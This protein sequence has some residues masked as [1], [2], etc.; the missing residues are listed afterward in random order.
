[1]I[2]DIAPGAPS[3]EGYLFPDT[4]QFSRMMTMREMAAAMVC[5]FMAV[6]HQIGLAQPPATPAGSSADA[7]PGAGH[8]CVNTRLTMAEP[9]GLLVTASTRD[10]PAL[11]RTVI[12]AIRVEK[13]T[14]AAEERPLVASVYYNRL[15]K[16][17]ALN[18]D[19][20]VIM[21]NCSPEPTP[22][23]CTTPTCSFHPPTTP[24]NTPAFRPDQ[25]LT[26][27][28]ARSRR[29]CTP[30][31]PTT[32]I[33][34]PTPPGTIALRTR[35]KSTIRM[36]PPIVGPCWVT[37]SFRTAATFHP[38]LQNQDRCHS[39]YRFGSLFDGQVCLPQQ[40]V[41]FGRM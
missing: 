1:M 19:P 2:S 25:S 4:C 35:W 11:Q 40:T 10:L 39:V 22:E 32:I 23:P 14:S 28:G 27:A 41:C 26:Q 31:N 33:L 16:N 9:N 30:P 7:Y 12:M 6:A 34:C 8:N 20:S 3:L 24:T 21:R 13:E 5:Q 38:P 37:S 17:I 29:R 36:Q 18:A 15:A